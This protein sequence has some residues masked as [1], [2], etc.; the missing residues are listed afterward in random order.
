LFLDEPFE[1]ID[2]AG[3]AMLKDWLKRYASDGRTVFMTSHVLETVE[4]LCDDVAIINRGQVVWKGEVKALQS[5][6]S[7]SL[8]GHEFTSLE[9]L[10]LFLVGERHG[11][12]AWL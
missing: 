10:F 9:S 2:P 5:G 1:S 8:N 6:G 12:L 11:R 7:I 4:R 3:V